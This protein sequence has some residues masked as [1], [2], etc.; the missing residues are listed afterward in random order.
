NSLPAFNSN[1][2]LVALRHLKD[3]A[4]VEC[5]D[6][7]PEAGGLWHYTETS[8]LTHANLE[9]DVYYKQNGY[10]HPSIH[11]ELIANVPRYLMQYK[12]FPVNAIATPMFMLRDNFFSYLL[13]Y[14]SHFKLSKYIRL[15]RL[16]SS[17]RL[18]SGF[19]DKREKQEW[20]LT[21]TKNDHRRFVVKYCSTTKTSKGVSPVGYAQ[22]DYVVVCSGHNSFPIVPKID[23]AENFQ[24]LQMTAHHFRSYST[25]DF[26]HKNVLIIGARYS[27]PDMF[28]Q[29]LFN[30]YI[31]QNH[32]GTIYVS[33]DVSC[34]E[35]STD[36]AHLY[37][38]QKIILKNGRVKSFGKTNV[39]FHDDTQAEIDLV[40]YCCGYHFRFSF[41]ENE[42]KLINWSLNEHL[43][44]Y[45]GPLYSRMFCIKEPHLIFIGNH[46]H[47]I[48][49][50]LI[51]EKQCIVAKKVINN[52]IQLPSSQEML[53]SFHED[54]R[55]YLTLNKPLKD[56]YRLD[57][58]VN[59]WSYIEQLRQLA[60]M[61]GNEIV[62]Q[63]LKNIATKFLELASVGNWLSYRKYDFAQ[64]ELPGYRD[65]TDFL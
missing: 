62:D 19:Q 6:S 36:F 18:V 61:K 65:T 38:R 2:G 64:L 45:W 57:T 14:A 46:D 26:R 27:G 43:G 17:V 52:E 25:P 1:I 10:L 39:I 59:D 7:Q 8:E 20:G 21:S 3:V 44:K 30:P 47:S 34:L 56:Y 49:I 28:I 50:Q 24:G 55:K 37:A 41:L 58:S 11:E 53:K 51:M 5:F 9:S 40:I 22:F 13:S 35:K 32:V 42:D 15:N 31:D 29:L 63:T 4:D 54:L 33:G 48:I 60:K 23:G 12:D 16:V